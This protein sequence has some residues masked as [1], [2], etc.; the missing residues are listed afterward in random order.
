[1]GADSALHLRAAAPIGLELDGLQVA[2]AIAAV[3]RDRPF[4]LLFFGRLAVDDQSSQVGTMVARLL[5]IPSVGDVTRIEPGE[6]RVRFHHLVEGR[7]E[8]VECPLPA[9][10]TAQKGL[11]EPRYPSIKQIMTSKK[12]PLEVVEARLPEP[13]LEVVRLDLPPARQPGR[14]VG[15]GAAA[16]PELLRLLREEAKV[17]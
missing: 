6:G 9:A 11:A 3:L 17:L 5:G 4:D 12:K 10:A 7:V 13:A 2:S 16:V 8:V 1:M 14:I 15:T